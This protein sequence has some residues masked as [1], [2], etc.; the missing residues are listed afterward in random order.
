M[1]GRGDHNHSNMSCMIQITKT[2]SVVTRDS[3]YI[4]A[5]LITA[6]QHLSDQ[7]HKSTV[8]PVDKIL[9]DFEKTSSR[10]CDN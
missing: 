3:K 9:N 10:K 8:D 6:E 4:K 5:T 7:L 1:V 2:G